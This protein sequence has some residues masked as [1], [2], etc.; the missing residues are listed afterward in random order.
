MAKV[1]LKSIIIRSRYIQLT[2]GSIF[3]PPPPAEVEQ[4]NYETIICES[5]GKLV[6]N[7]IV[8]ETVSFGFFVSN[9][10]LQFVL[11]KDLQDK[12]KRET[13]K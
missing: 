10:I 6:I 1:F 13:Q 11:R 8:S 12:E 5:I 2:N 9:P 3:P 4:C 7:V